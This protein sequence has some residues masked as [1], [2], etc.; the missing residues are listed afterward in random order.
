MD[1]ILRRFGS[2]PVNRKSQIIEIEKSITLTPEFILNFGKDSLT[3]LTNTLDKATQIMNVDLQNANNAEVQEDNQKIVE[4][5]ST[6][7]C[8]LEN[9]VF[10]AEFFLRGKKTKDVFIDYH[11]LSLPDKIQFKNKQMLMDML[12]E[13]SVSLF[14]ASVL[15]MQSKMQLIINNDILK[16]VEKGTV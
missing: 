14:R 15:A 16:N 8:E 9:Y 6:I 4:T 2:L 7:I 5:L 1:S 13:K 12:E 11:S 10:A 3:T